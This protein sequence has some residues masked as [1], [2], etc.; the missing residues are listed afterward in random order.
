M[1][2]IP[3]ARLGTQR[4]AALL[5]ATFLMAACWA[6]PQ[7][8]P[9]EHA[10]QPAQALQA[11]IPVQAVPAGE[12]SPFAV[13]EALGAQCRA[14]FGGDPP[15]QGAACYGTLP[16]H[17]Q[18]LLLGIP[19]EHPYL[20]D[21]Q[22]EQ[23]ANKPQWFRAVPGYGQRPDF[24]TVLDGFGLF[25][26]RSFEGRD[27]ETT[28][29]VVYGPDCILD[30]HAQRDV[31]CLPGGPGTI[32]EIKLYRVRAGGLPED[33]TSE[34][35]PPPPTLTMAERRRYGIHLRPP[36]EGEAED[37]DIGLDVRRLGNTPVMRWVID[38]PEEGD[39]ERP[40]I[41]DS[42]PRGF[43]QQAHFGFL[44]WTGERFELR[45]KIPLALWACGVGIPGD[46]SCL[47][48]FRGGGDPYL[49]QGPE[50]DDADVARP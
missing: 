22:R 1:T 27:P 14:N 49:V 36:E 39:Y 40:R 32:R 29:Y 6:A 8:V 13:E 43:I 30:R 17:M 16:R 5:A 44:V 23:S 20:T 42:D 38:P 35:A 47:E 28:V 15:L 7:A 11:G 18:E 9:V 2:R 46:G 24:V 21:E 37:T 34:L 12:G 4:P 45:E 31:R 25:W 19:S 48:P 26:V 10:S 41:P 33:V 3:V 50:A